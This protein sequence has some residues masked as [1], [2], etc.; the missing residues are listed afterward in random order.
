MMV[1]NYE[2]LES[3]FTNSVCIAENCKKLQGVIGSED[4]LA[5]LIHA[6]PDSIAS[7]FA[8]KRLFWPKN[9]K[10]ECRSNK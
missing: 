6:D 8:L 1:G 7:A 10:S 4:T 5:I 3:P 2:I 9:E